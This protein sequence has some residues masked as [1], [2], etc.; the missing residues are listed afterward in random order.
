MSLLIKIKNDMNLARKNGDKTK[1]PKLSTLIGEI[2]S[3]EA[4]KTSEL[5]DQETLSVIKKFINNLDETINIL[6]E[7]N[8]DYSFLEQ[9]RQIYSVY[10]PKEMNQQEI[11]EFFGHLNSEMQ[12][13]QKMAALKKFAEENG[14]IYNGKLASEIAKGKKSS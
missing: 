10:L 13:G 2:Q 6:K 9:E 4:N 7:K 5:T 1:L 11:E 3:K 12:M 8:Q 14:V